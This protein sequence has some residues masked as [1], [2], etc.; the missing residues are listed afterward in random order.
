VGDHRRA[1]S[2]YRAALDVLTASGNQFIEALTRGV[3]AGLQLAEG[4]HAAARLALDEAA[5]LRS[6]TPDPRQDQRV[7]GCTAALEA[8]EQ[9]PR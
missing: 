5:A 9:R 4:D 8:A 3:L 1:V 2:Y 6:Q 7:A